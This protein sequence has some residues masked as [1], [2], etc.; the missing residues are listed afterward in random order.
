[1]LIILENKCKNRSVPNAE[2]HQW[3]VSCVPFTFNY[4]RSRRLSFKYGL[5]QN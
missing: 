2:R 4:T 5:L 1:M 3:L